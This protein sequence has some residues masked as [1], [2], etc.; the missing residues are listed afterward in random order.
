MLY[1]EADLLFDL[2]E[3]WLVRPGEGTRVWEAKG[4]RWPTA[5]FRIGSWDGSI[6]RITERHEA[7]D[8]GWSSS[9]PYANLEALGDRPP[10]VGTWEEGDV[11]VVGW[12]FRVD[13]AGVAL[14]AELPTPLFEESWRDVDHV[15][16]SV[17]RR[18]R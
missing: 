12:Y 10:L 6:E 18:P 2:P 7:A 14:V 17:R 3:G 8:Q 11:L 15:V 5:T 13:G 16:R 4:P 9:G 1:R